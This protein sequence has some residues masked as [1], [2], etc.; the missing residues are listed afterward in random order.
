MFMKKLAGHLGGHGNK[1]WVDV[2]SLKFMKESYNVKSMI[3]VG[4]GPGD[5]AILAQGL[6]IDAIGIDGDYTIDR[7]FDCIIHDFTLGDM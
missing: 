4:C 5:Q 6:G 3:D 1:T 2:G 7:D